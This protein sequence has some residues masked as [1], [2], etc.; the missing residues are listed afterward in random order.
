MPVTLT[1]N[2]LAL[3]VR[4]TTDSA[5]TPAEPYNNILS[6]LLS[7]GTSIVNAY[8]PNAPDDVLDEAIVVMA[9]YILESPGFTRMPQDAFYNSGAKSLL[10]PWREIAT[11]KVT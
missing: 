6:R 3:E 11:A 7:V 4:V 10:A 2:H 1:L 8:A 9:G 5:T